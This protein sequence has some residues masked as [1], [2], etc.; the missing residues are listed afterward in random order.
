MRTGE[1]SAS[2]YSRF[3][4]RG[5]RSSPGGALPNAFYAKLSAACFVVGGCMELFMI[6]TGF[7]DK[8]TVIEAERRR[9]AEEYA[10]ANVWVQDMLKDHS[11]K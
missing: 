9:D 4:A 11:R 2:S 10:A 8:V 7:Y 1:A 3:L 6:H 5:P